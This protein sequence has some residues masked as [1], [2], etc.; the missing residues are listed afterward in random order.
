MSFVSPGE[1]CEIYKVTTQTLR[2][3]A[4]D[5]KIEYILTE[6]GHYRYKI[7]ENKDEKKYKCI[8]ARV[9]SAKQKGDLKRQI[10]YLKKLYPGYTVYSDIGSGINFKRKEFREVLELLFERSL[11]ELVVAS[12]DRFCRIGGSEFFKWLFEYFGAT[13]TVVQDSKLKSREEELA[14]DLIEIITV[15]TARYHGS[16]KYGSNEENSDISNGTT[17]KSI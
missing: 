12:D 17:D 10:Q 16:R 1:A 7:E 4:K 5:G 3:W 6:G 13:F 15:F 2:Q 8:Y 11:E 9:S 14:S